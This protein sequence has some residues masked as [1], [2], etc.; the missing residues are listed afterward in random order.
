LW[1][2]WGEGIGVYKCGF[3]K[4]LKENYEGF[5]AEGYFGKDCP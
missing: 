3:V 5:K 1:G 4:I 2:D